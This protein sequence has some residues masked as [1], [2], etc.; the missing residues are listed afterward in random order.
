EMLAWLK[1][2][3]AGNPLFVE[4]LVAH[5]AN[6]RERFSISP[7]LSSLLRRR[8][9][10]LS[11]RARIVLHN[12]AMLGKYSTLD[13]I[14]EATQLPRFELV[15]AVGEL[16]TMRLIRAE[17]PNIRPLH[18]LIADVASTRTSAVELRLSHQCVALALESLLSRE[19][20]AAL[21]WECAEH[22]LS[23]Q[24]TAR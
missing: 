8:V 5:Y 1:E 16:E 23:A 20:P 12:C 10:C 11:D 4:S 13:T 9:E 3:S 2:V 6:T 15:R 19:Q 17:G 7:T 24:N 18:A 22:W 14:A 21:V